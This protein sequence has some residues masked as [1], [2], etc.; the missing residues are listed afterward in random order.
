MAPFHNDFMCSSP[1]GRVNKIK[2]LLPER[3][4]TANEDSLLTFKLDRPMTY[5]VFPTQEVKTHY[6]PCTAP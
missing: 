2:T 3:I 6:K 5:L 1:R 4:Q